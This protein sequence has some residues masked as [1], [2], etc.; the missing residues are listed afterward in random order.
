M[1]GLIAALV[2]IIVIVVVALIILVLNDRVHHLTQCIQ[3][4]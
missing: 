1:H 2:P 3:H 4:R